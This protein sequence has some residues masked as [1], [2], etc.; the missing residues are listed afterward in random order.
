VVACASKPRCILNLDNN[1][2][3]LQ[4]NKETCKK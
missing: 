2:L 3:K 4:N 1:I